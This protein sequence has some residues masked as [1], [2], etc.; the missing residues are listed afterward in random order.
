MTPSQSAATAA[1][2]PWLERHRHRLPTL[3]R[4]DAPFWDEVLARLKTID[5]GLWLEVSEDAVPGEIVL[6]AGGD[7]ALFDLVEAVAARAPA[8]PGWTVIAL[9]PAMGFGGVTCWEGL[10][11][12]PK[13]LWFEPLNNPKAPQVLGLRV[14]AP[15]HTP[16]A[17][18]NFRNGLLTL[19]DTG[20]GERHAAARVHLVD[21][22]PVP[23]DPD[24][25]GYLPLVDLAAYLDWRD[26]RRANPPSSA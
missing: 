5:D 26:R 10:V 7:E 18:P 11:L 20:L 15:G 14:A 16:S 6:T 12:D 2:W 3:V 22:G 8:M 4:P 25:A 21:V 17:D 9:K 24:A 13:Q 1:F 23:P 19:L